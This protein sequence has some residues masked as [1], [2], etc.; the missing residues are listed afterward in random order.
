M[1]RNEVRLTIFDNVPDTNDVN[2]PEHNP[3]DTRIA[4]DGGADVYGKLKNCYARFLAGEK[5]NAQ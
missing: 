4:N 1:L 5:R 2:D 3:V